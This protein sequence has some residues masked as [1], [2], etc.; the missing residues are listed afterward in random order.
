MRDHPPIRADAGPL[1]I[2]AA[3]GRLPIEVAVAALAAGRQSHIIAI[4]GF[5]APEVAGFSHEWV[6]LGQLGRILAGLRRAGCRDLVIIGALERPD[7]WRLRFD[8]GALRRL[9]TLL[10]LTRGGDDSVLRRVVRFFEAE[11]F[12]VR[13][14]GEVAPHLLA[15]PGVWG[16]TAPSAPQSAMVERAARLITALGPFDVGQGVVADAAGI[17][18]IEGVRGT[19]AMLRSLELAGPADERSR[20]GVLVKLAKPDQEMR[21]DLPTIGPDTV[22]VAREAGLSGIAVGAGAAVVID[23]PEIILAA[24]VADIFLAGIERPS[25]ASPDNPSPAAD[26]VPADMSAVLA[27]LSR[28]APTPADRRDIAVGRRLLPVLRA[29]GAGLAA[30]IAREHVLAIA[31]ALPVDR[32]VSGLGRN[33]SWGRRTFKGQIGVLVFDIRQTGSEV[34]P[35][36]PGLAVFRALVEAGL[37][38][39]VCLGGPLPEAHRSELVGWANDARVFLMAQEPAPPIE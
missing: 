27:V 23:L 18:A 4:E 33:A 2:V 36:L 15:R 1:G 29:H 38:G 37:A 28:R 30:V 17:I 10:R 11:G 35:A 39:L 25:L 6:N 34:S 31:G 8:F 12:A 3:A 14:I 9:G 26:A 7:L 21:V 24:D 5:A 16:S 32:I 13:G 22:A 20:G 19:D